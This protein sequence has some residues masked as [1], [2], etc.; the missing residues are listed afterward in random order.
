MS[1]LFSASSSFTAGANEAYREYGRLKH[2]HT[3]KRLRPHL[4]PHQVAIANAVFHF[5]RY[6]LILL[7][8]H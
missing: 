4:Q 2:G 1:D 8:I 5:V 7:I 3:P 6:F